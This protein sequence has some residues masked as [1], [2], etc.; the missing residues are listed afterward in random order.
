MEVD[1]QMPEESY[2]LN[3]IEMECVNEGDLSGKELDMKQLPKVDASPQP[4]LKSK[5]LKWHMPIIGE[6]PMSK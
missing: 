6:V 5:G 2:N 1:N 4:L 3:D